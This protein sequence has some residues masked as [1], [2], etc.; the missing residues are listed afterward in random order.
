MSKRARKR[1]DRKKRAPNHATPPP[2]SPPAAPF[3]Q[4]GAIILS[5]RAHPVGP[6]PFSVF[7]RCG[8]QLTCN[9]AV[10]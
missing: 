7:L 10:S 4:R 5:R 3:K 2:A 1:R 9:A 8:S 6:P